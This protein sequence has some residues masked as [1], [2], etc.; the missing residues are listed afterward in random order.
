[1]FAADRSVWRILDANANRARE[2][3][4]VIEEY[5]RFVL[6]DEPTCGRIKQLRHEFSSQINRLPG[7]KLLAARDTAGDVGVGITASLEK[8]RAGA[9]DVAAASFKRLAE[10][11]RAIEEYGKIVDTAFAEAIERIRYDTYELERRMAFSNNAAGR[12]TDVKLYVLVSSELCTRP[13]LDV[14]KETLD[15]GADCIQLREKDCGDAELLDLAWSV[16]ELT[17]AAGRMFI[18]NDR[19]DL[20]VLTSADGV[21]VGQTD[22]PVSAVRKIV[23]PGIVVGKSTHSR[24]ESEAALEEGLDYIAVGPMYSTRTKPRPVA[25]VGF[26]RDVRPTTSLP[27]V[28]IGGIRPDNLEELRT[29][30]ADCVA[31]SG[32]IIASDDVRGAT[33]SFTSLVRNWRQAPK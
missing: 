20:A 16:R 6:D 3:L 15:G 28:A 18:V 14:V 33:E 2:A 22:L 32:A 8:S 10:S 31:V 25:G 24:E 5:A 26:L 21:H 4:R 19:A 9:S 23:G 30:G 29:A 12:M 13:L 27:I 1:M 17:K 7:E 11:L